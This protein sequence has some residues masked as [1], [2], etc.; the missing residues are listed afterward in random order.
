MRGFEIEND[1]VEHPTHAAADALA[2]MRFNYD[3][4]EYNFNQAFTY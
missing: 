1:S 4:F 2:V 3:G